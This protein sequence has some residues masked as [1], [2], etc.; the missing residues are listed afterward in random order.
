M[1]D[2]VFL[3]SLDDIDRLLLEAMAVIIAAGHLPIWTVYDHPTDFPDSYV[4]RLFGTDKP[5]E[6]VVVRTDVEAIRD[7]MQRLGLVKLMR[8]ESDDPKIME[9]WI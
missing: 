3:A 5:T 9:T 1:V 6:W 7:C 2:R 4:A 8:N